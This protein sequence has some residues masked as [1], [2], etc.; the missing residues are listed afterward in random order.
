MRNEQ[1]FQ[2]YK[3]LCC[4]ALQA[5]ISQVV[6]KRYFLT[7]HAGTSDAHIH[8]ILRQ[9]SGIDKDS[10]S[11]CLASQFSDF[12]REAA[13]DPVLSQLYSRR[14]LE[15]ILVYQLQ[16][17]VVQLAIGFDDPEGNEAVLAKYY[18][19]FEDLLYEASWITSTIYPLV[20]FHSEY[21]WEV[22]QESRRNGEAIKSVIADDY[23]LSI[24][25]HLEIK[26]LA[27]FMTPS[28][29]GKQ[30]GFFPYHGLA[31]LRDFSGSHY[32]V[33]AK[34]TRAKSSTSQHNL[35]SYTIGRRIEAVENDIL[36]A[37]R[38]IV[39]LPE[40]LLLALRL[41]KPGDVGVAPY[42][43]TSDYTKPLY[44]PRLYPL[45]FTE[46]A[47][48]EVY[49]DAPYILAP[50]EG[51]KFRKLYYAI[52][53]V[54]SVKPGD[55]EHIDIAQRYFQYSYSHKFTDQPRLQDRAVSLLF[56][57]EALL[58]ERGEDRK[59]LQ[60]LAQGLIDDPHGRV[61]KDIEKAYDKVRNC[62]AHGRK[63]EIP[64]DSAFVKRLEA[65][66]RQIIKRAIGLA[67]NKDIRSKEDL[68]NAVDTVA[69]GTTDK[70]QLC[71]DAESPFS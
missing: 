23:T 8:R 71:Q 57:L 51:D 47:Q 29:I 60:S 67:I 28:L 69:S 53:N 15:V 38:T 20:N 52:T 2:K 26:Q 1:L 43:Y 18:S 37:A 40:F 19:W 3:S 7:W 48:V 56:A 13:Q 10:S 21:E 58:L 59:R 36:Y 25:K 49:P 41:F 17:P 22:H 45:R 30:D 62:V 46:L 64:L 66:V 24:D 12:I 5:I 35:M 42:R 31:V 50:G 32:V 33:E 4:S 68:Q 39:D 16:Y 27:L 11:P 61:K 14:D 54:L 34:A 55:L 65:Y 70:M 9:F 63:P 6:D 44:M